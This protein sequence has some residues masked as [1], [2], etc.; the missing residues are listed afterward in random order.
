[1]DK[2]ATAEAVGDGEPGLQTASSKAG[3][4][5]GPGPRSGSLQGLGR[6]GGPGAGPRPA[7]P[8]HRRCL[9]H[10]P[11]AK[12]DACDLRNSRRAAH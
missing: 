7:R 6:N 10:I 8:S 11:V 5:T 1:M 9:S 3:H 12:R 2:G 4:R